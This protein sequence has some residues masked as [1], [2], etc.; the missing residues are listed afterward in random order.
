[1]DL[2]ERGFRN[3]VAN[4]MVKQTKK[5]T[6][7]EEAVRSACAREAIRLSVNEH[8]R[9][10]SRLKGVKVTRTIAD[11][12]IQTLEDTYLKIEKTQAIVVRGK[13]LEQ[14]KSEAANII[15]DSLE[16]VGVTEILVDDEKLLP[17]AGVLLDTSRESALSLLDRRVLKLL[18]TCIAP[19]GV[20]D[21]TDALT[22]TMKLKDSTK[23][24]KIPNR[25]ITVIKV[26][27][28]EKL[29]AT[30][31]PESKLDLGRG[32]GK[33]IE[34]TIRG[35]VIGVIFDTRGRPLRHPIKKDSLRQWA[36]TLT[37]G[38]GIP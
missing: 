14:S 21:A 16:P 11:T 12:F 38:G 6:E 20:S 23:S 9:I 27:P 36:N 35:G 10:A 29:E 34:R 13:A 2:S 7:E 3:I 5:L 25:N 26:A 1:M 37:A 31:T 33:I 32:K 19:S 24:L 4:L 28:D 30:L 22:L 15:L 17:H 8:K 18:A